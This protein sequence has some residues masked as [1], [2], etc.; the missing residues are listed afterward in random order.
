MLG[1][2]KKKKKEEKKKEKKERKKESFINDVLYC[3]LSLLEFGCKSY[4]GS[5]NAIVILCQYY[6][7]LHSKICPSNA[8]HGLM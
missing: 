7:L 2:K 6:F 3:H 4:L 1:R 5:T 8:T